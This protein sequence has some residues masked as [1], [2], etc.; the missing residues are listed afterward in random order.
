[1]LAVLA[2]LIGVGGGALA[3]QT[4]I[5]VSLRFGAPFA[6]Y[7]PRPY[8][9]GY[10]ND[11]DYDD[12]SRYGYDDDHRYRGYGG[13][14]PRPTIVVVRPYRRGRGFV[15]RGRQGHRHHHW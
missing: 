3:A 13:Y 6:V 15:E 12:D 4:R 8:G 5:R 1:M 9:Y 7:H 11:Y 14:D 10:R 2:V